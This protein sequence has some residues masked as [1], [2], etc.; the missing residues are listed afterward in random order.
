MFYKLLNV[1]Q[2]VVIF[3]FLQVVNCCFDIVLSLVAWMLFPVEGC[4]LDIKLKGKRHVCIALKGCIYIH[5]YLGIN[6]GNV[7]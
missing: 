3:L 7:L 2:N 5:F 4:F 1:N 6:M